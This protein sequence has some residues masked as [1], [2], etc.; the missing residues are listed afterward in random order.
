[1]GDRFYS[2]GYDQYV[3]DALTWADNVADNLFAGFRDEIQASNQDI[4]D[5]LL[6]IYDLLTNWHSTITDGDGDT[7]GGNATGHWQWNGELGEWEWVGGGLP[8]TPPPTTPGGGGPGGPFV[9]DINVISDV[10]VNSVVTVVP[11]ELFTTY[12]ES[13]V[14]AEINRRNRLEQGIN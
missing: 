11:S 2:E 13:V 9:Q 1:M 5:E 10:N 4:V 12:V 8:T 7:G 3:I 14:N 6:A